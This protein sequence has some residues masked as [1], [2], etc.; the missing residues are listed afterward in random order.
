MDNNLNYT[1]Y[2]DDITL[3]STDIS[4][5]RDAAS[6]VI[7]EIYKVF[8]L[9]GFEPNYS[10]TR[11]VPPGGR[12]V[13]LGLLVDGETPRLTKAFRNQLSQHLHFV[14]RD[15]VGPV[16]HAEAKGFQSVYGLYNHIRG[17][18]SYAG[19]INPEYAKSEW[20]RFNNVN[21]P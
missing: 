13:V 14:S 10:K 21:W 16:R 18:I 15:D 2:A 8:R 17:L 20:V 5:S 11:I 6:K 12:K 4:F 9:C 3:S 7:L 1:R 19:Q